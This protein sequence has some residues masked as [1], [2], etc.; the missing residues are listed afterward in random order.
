M[1]DDT[2]NADAV[3]SLRTVRDLF[4]LAVTRFRR[5][6]LSYGHGAG[7]AIDEAAF[8]VLEGLS[9]PIDRLD[10]YL[11]ARLLPDE[12]RH[13]L[14]LIEA[15]VTTRKPL[16]YLL[17]RAYIQG[18]A[19]RSDERAIVPRSFI[20]ELLFSELVAGGGD[21]LIADPSRIERVLDLC[22]GSGCLAILA[23][24]VFPNASV[25]AVDLSPDALTLAAENVAGHGLQDRVNLLCGDL[26][27]PVADRQYDLILANPPYVD[28]E[29][30]A[31]LPA[32]FRHEPRMALAAGLD[33]L[34]VVR[35][36]LAEAG[37]RL[38]PMGGL[39]CEIGTGRAALE[40][41]LPDIDFL[42][43]E[44]EESAGE[45]FWLDAG[46]LP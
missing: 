45:V 10:P 2:E 41:G 9:L 42:W 36:I 23:A 24:H 20:G 13:L 37:A 28:A 19:F 38:N 30:M 40:A 26:F 5:A 16:P 44:T 1:S 32:E 33:G 27:A 46:Q 29:A 18:F 4:R 3:R 31:R 43:L 11:D 22:T 21:A 25:D 15:R 35:R 12:R 17:G 39:M 34:D 6:D 7:N 8:L 14:D